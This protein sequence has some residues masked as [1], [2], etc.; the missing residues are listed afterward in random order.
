VST[1]SA[2]IVGVVAV[3]VACVPGR[4]NAVD[5]CRDGGL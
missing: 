2:G 3:V 1:S 5:L 4:F